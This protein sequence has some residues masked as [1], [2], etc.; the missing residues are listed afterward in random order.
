M[1]SL[2]KFRE[3]GSHQS[4]KLSRVKENNVCMSAPI[5]SY[6]PMEQGDEA[7]CDNLE[8]NFPENKSN[9]LEGKGG[10]GKKRQKPGWTKSK[11]SCP[12]EVQKRA[13][14]SLERLILK[15]LTPVHGKGLT[16][17]ICSKGQESSDAT[18]HDLGTNHRA[19]S[20]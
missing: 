10:Q 11:Q 14:R 9:H 12:T 3:P 7:L 13:G 2:K 19:Q 8:L 18:Q 5:D 17:A 20:E 6:R 16:R 15:Q 1:R 4:Q